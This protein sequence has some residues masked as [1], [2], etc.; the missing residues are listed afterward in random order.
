MLF[1][2]TLNWTYDITYINLH[3][4]RENSIYCQAHYR[5]DWPKEVH[6]MFHK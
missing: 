1:S 4:R 3:D 5:L 2:I 6:L